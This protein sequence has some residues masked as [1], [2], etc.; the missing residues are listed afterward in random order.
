MV[1]GNLPPNPVTSFPYFGFDDKLLKTIVKSE[2]STP[3]PIQAQA[4]P[5]ALQG[6]DVL[7]IAQTDSDKAPSYEYSHIRFSMC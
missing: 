7:G 1:S 4:V 5:C 3:T 6:R 2:Y